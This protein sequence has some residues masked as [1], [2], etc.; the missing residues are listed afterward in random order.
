MSILKR[1]YPPA[2]ALINAKKLGKNKAIELVKAIGLREYG[3]YNNRFVAD[4]WGDFE[5]G[6]Q[7]P[8]K[9]LGAL[10]N[11]DTEY[12][13]LEVIR[14]NTSAV[15]EGLAIAA[16]LSGANAVEVVLPYE[17][18]DLTEK[19]C[20]A[21]KDFDLAFSISYGMVN[22]RAVGNS[23]IHHFETSAAITALFED[24]C[25]YMK[26]AVAAVKKYGD[27]I[28]KAVEFPYGK[29]IAEIAGIDENAGIKAIAV[30]STLY[31]VSAFSL[32]VDEVFPLENGVITLY[33]SK[34][35][36]ADQAEK[37][38]LEVRKTGCGKCTFC[39]EG[40]IQIHTMFKNITGAKGKAT[41]I[42]MIKEIGEAMRF[43]SLCSIGLTGANFALSS[44]QSFGDEV[45][46]HI[47]RKK[48]PAESCSA[49]MNVYIAP[50]ICDGC[51]D[52][53]DVCEADCIEGKPGFIHMIDE[54]DCTKC[55]KCIEVCRQKAIIKTKGRI[56]KLPERLTRVGK[57]NKR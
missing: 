16:Y 2:T 43:S 52:C 15:I 50:S 45:E 47:R 31:G 10:N 24:S 53:L 21:F 38:A 5:S 19:V 42:G 39:R 27:T 46:A 41:D 34:C 26:T 20:E 12:M 4:E 57:F 54:F 23:I 17:G 56:P 37:A 44:L 48:C 40:A 7:K 8:E 6:S 32:V 28:D 14:E 29:T 18:K 33:D 25:S 30:G 49:F 3:V 51:G 13:L 9:I 11:S 55:G 22:V 35:C 1:N 36:I